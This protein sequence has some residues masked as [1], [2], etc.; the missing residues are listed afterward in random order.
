MN[1]R[2]KKHRGL[3]H[4]LCIFVS[5]KAHERQKPVGSEASASGEECSGT[6]EPDESPLKA[7]SRGTW[8]DNRDKSEIISVSVPTIQ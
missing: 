2:D 1:E 5:R 4:V 8:K 7:G 6:E 3:K